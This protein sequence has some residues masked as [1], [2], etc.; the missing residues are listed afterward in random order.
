MTATV[1][2]D[3][4]A[5]ALD[6]YHR[7]QLRQAQYDEAAVMR[8]VLVNLHGSDHRARR[9][10]ENRLFR[11]QTLHHYET[12]VFPRVLARLL[13]PCVAAGRAELVGLGHRAMLEIAA[14]IA[15]IDR[16]GGAA[17]EQR[18]M[19]HLKLFTEALTLAQ[20]TADTGERRAAIRRGLREWTEDFFAPSAARR[21]GLLKRRAGGG[22]AEGEL[23][24]DILTTLLRH[25]GE[26]DLPD[27]VLV[28]E[29]AFFFLVA[30][31]TSAT[32]F[33]RAVH[34]ILEWVAG[35]PDR[36]A[37]FLDE[38]LLVQRCVHETIRLNSS[39]PVGMR[40]AAEPVRLRSGVDIPAGTTVIIDLRAVGRDESVYGADAGVFDP[41]R[42]LPAGTTPYGLSFAAGAHFCIGQDLAV[43]TV[44]RGGQIPDA[45]LFG[46]VTVAVGELLKAGVRPD[47]D[48]PAEPDPTT[49]RRYWSR[50]P[51]LLAG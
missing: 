21:R 42:E 10:V 7:P 24:K 48:R 30:S 39:S 19:A 41:D 22:L 4:Y 16:A 25:Q 18:L 37:R 44:P 33:V 43:G 45:H 31:H 38:P 29:T 40:Y 49:R 5:D 13:A 14:L 15:G 2:L 46:V 3:T 35:R 20:S 11:R 28:R 34:H 32:A 9:R 23:P 50:Y 47:P 6:A 17:E 27:D 36:A 8:D 26:L 1:V 12:E 51:V